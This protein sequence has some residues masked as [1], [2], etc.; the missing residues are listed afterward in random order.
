[1][2]NL[3]IDKIFVVNAHQFLQIGSQK[4]DCQ[5]FNMKT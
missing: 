3:C 2:N 1:M 5:K 4:F